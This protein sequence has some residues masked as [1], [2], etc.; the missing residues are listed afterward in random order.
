MYAHECI[1]VPIRMHYR[2]ST[3][4]T[5]EFKSKLGFNQDDITFTKE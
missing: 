4:K 3:P 1:I 5:I 2:V